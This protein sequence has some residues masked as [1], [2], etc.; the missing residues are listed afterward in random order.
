M[1]S[2]N[3]FKNDVLIIGESGSTLSLTSVTLDSAG[4]YHCRASTDSQ[5]VRST[6]AILTVKGKVIY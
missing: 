3:R 1:I 6:D 4:T 2:D 5:G